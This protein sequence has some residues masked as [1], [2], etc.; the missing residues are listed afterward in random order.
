M[1]SHL[2]HSNPLLSYAGQRRRCITD[3]RNLPHPLHLMQTNRINT[4]THHSSIQLDF[5][6][7]PD[8]RQVAVRRD[9]DLRVDEPLLFVAQ[10][11]TDRIAQLRNGRVLELAAAHGRRAGRGMQKASIDSGEELMLERRPFM[12]ARITV[13]SGE[14]V[15]DIG[16]GR[17]I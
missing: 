10:D 8:H 3:P 2:L 5:I 4:L 6:L 17:N 12:H 13:V 11:V 14:V 1:Q 7:R 15:E 16:V 9:L